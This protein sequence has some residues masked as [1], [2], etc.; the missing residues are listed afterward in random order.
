MRYKMILMDIDDTLFDFQAGNRRAVG[1]LMEELNL[2]SETVFDEYQAINHACWEALERGEMTQATLHVERFRRFLKT[3]NREDDPKAVADRFAEL[4]GQQ[5]IPFPDAERVVKMLSEKVPVVL[6][7]NG[8]TVIQKQRMTLSPIR[9]WISGMVI[10]QEVGASKPDPKIFEIALNGL[11]PKDALM[12]GDSIPSDVRG[13]NH[14]GIDVCW[15]NPHGKTLPDD[16]HAEYT[17]HS[18]MEILP[19]ALQP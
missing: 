17:V 7:T 8:I 6:L 3:K 11:S 15:Y 18:L 14:A 13:A 2:A 4:L 1:L 5:A 19:I 9:N 12:V 10:S 16:V